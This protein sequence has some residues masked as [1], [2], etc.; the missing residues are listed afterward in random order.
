MNKTQNIQNV[1]LTLKSI[2]SDDV[3]FTKC[4]DILIKTVGLEVTIDILIRL[5]K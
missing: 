4:L 3:R 5:F 2:D 1:L